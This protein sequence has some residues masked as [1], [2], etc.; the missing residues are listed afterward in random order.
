MFRFWDRA[1]CIIALKGSEEVA[2]P[3]DFL[4]E[5]KY[6]NDIESVLS[7]YIALKR[8]GSNLVGL[9]PFH[10]EKTPSFTVYPENG[11]YYC[12]GCGQGGD[13]ITFTMKIENLDYIDA[14][15]RLAEKA[16]LR[17]PEDNRD[18]KELKLKNDIYAV[19]A[20]AGRFFHSVLMSPQGKPGLDYFLG[21]GLNLKTVKRFGL[22][23]APDDWH[24]LENHLRSKGFTDYIISAADLV[25]KSEKKDKF[26]KNITYDRFRNRIMFPIINIHGKVIGFSGR[27]MPGNE[28]QGGKYINTSDTPVYK[29][30]HN[31]FALNYAKAVCSKQAI[32]VE[33]NM[34]VIALHQAGF[35]TAVAALGTSFT[36]EQARLLARYTKEVV[37]TMDADSAGE[38]ATDRA[39]GILEP[40]GVS[41]RVLRLPDCKDPDEFIKKHGNAR[42]QKLLD[43]AMSALEYKLLT[44]A[45]GI[46]L[47]ATDGKLKY[48]NKACEVL[49]ATN[50]PIAIDLYTGKLSAKYGVSKERLM[51]IVKMSQE[52]RRNGEV[53]RELH[54]IIAPQ[55]AKKDEINPQRTQFKLAAKAEETV[56]SVLV[57]HPD[58]LETTKAKL[59]PSDFL[60]DFNRKLFERVVEIL[61]TGREFDLVLLGANFS[62]DEIGYITRL[63]AV[64]TANENA[65]KVLGD[66]IEVILNEKRSADKPNV[67]EMNDDDWAKEMSELIKS[68]KKGKT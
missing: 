65:Q 31:M 55:T 28:K 43:S 35:P 50:D 10:N 4:M 34:D 61:E 17:M 68:K 66:S 59:D 3:Q 5:L 18:D 33:G 53:R 8:R 46:D 62:P 21:R 60:T 42:F 51:Q 16:G 45:R 22:G 20:E 11:S 30:S 47:D 63:L 36:E 52:K 2:L 67:S 12:F 24:A 7:P 56:I 27:A 29:K 1:R 54:E 14:V 37:L 38:K 58:M 9:C 13:I 23:F 26:G 25:G 19:N 49:A 48:L 57:R 6:R 15:R 64:S 41:V 39:I 32:L 44:V 40:V